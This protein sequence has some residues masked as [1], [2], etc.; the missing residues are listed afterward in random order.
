MNRS[1]PAHSGTPAAPFLPLR[2]GSSYAETGRRVTAG[3][4]RYEDMSNGFSE[5]FQEITVP[6]SK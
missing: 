1:S 6:P 2:S 3:D 4:R 5:D